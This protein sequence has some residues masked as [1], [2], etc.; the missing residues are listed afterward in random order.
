MCLLEILYFTWK[1]RDKIIRHLRFSSVS[2]KVYQLIY[3]FVIKETP[4]SKAFTW[5]IEFY[6]E[7]AAIN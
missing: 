1:Q 2:Y 7:A 4:I 6:E 5:N 3:F